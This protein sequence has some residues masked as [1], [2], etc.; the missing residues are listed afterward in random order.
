ML[1]HMS[2]YV[3]IYLCMPILYY[4]LT[5]IL[6]VLTKQQTVTPAMDKNMVGSVGAIKRSKCKEDGLYCA[7]FDNESSPVMLCKLAQTT[8]E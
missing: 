3:L 7:V 5:N 1:V 2:R 8:K 4:F 6:R